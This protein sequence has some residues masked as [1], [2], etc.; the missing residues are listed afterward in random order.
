MNEDFYSSSQAAQMARELRAV[1]LSICLSRE[2]ICEILLH[3]QSLCFFYQQRF[4]EN[5]TRRLALESLITSLSAN[6]S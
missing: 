3:L 6:L 5:S 1:E 4:T 2:T